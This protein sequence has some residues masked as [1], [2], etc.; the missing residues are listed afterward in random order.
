MY[1]FS[2]FFAKLIPQPDV[3]QILSFWDLSGD[4]TTH[5]GVISSNLVFERSYNDFATFTHV[6]CARKMKIPFTKTLQTFLVARCAKNIRK[7][8]QAQRTTQK[9]TLLE[10]Q[11]GAPATDKLVPF[12][13]RCSHARHIVAKVSKACP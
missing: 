3:S 10:V 9:N 8:R 5:L 6:S 1:R 12:L 7:Q 2:M 13:H 11:M 4:T